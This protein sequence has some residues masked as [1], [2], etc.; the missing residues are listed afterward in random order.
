VNENNETGLEKKKR[1][2]VPE[3]GSIKTR[4]QKPGLYFWVRSAKVGSIAFAGDFS[5]C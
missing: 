3:F 2:F 4:A 1:W 5:K